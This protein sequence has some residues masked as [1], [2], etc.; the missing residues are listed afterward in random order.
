MTSGKGNMGKTPEERFFAHTLKQ[1]RRN[2]PPDT[3]PA[4][5]VAQMRQQ[6]EL[7]TRCPSE[8]LDHRR[9]STKLSAIMDALFPPEG[10]DPELSARNRAI[11]ERRWIDGAKRK[12]IAAEFGVTEQRVTSI[13]HYAYKRVLPYRLELLSFLDN[14]PESMNVRPLYRRNPHLLQQPN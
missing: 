2:P 5:Y 10:P 14:Q 8:V 9:V 1:A 4:A 13:E 7:L 3:L 6:A 11:L 12:E